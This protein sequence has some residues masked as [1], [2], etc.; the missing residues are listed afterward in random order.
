MTSRKPKPSVSPLT[1]WLSEELKLLTVT[2]QRR[3]PPRAG[4]IWK[5]E[6]PPADK[7]LPARAKITLH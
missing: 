7:S 6:E 5:V 3:T 4:Q 2:S 1:E